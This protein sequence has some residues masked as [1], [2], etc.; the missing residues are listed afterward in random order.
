MPSFLPTSRPTSRLGP[1]AASTEPPRV[2][3]PHTSPSTRL[4]K[5]YNE[6]HNHGSC[7]PPGICVCRPPWQGYD[8]SERHDGEPPDDFSAD[9]G[10]VYVHSPPNELGL[11]AMR[12]TGLHLDALYSA[13]IHFF[14]RLMSDFS[15]RTRDPR[16]ARLFYVPTFLIPIFTNIVYDKGVSHQRN[17]VAALEARDPL[18]ASAWHHN[19]S[20]VVFF[21]AGDKG[22]CLWQRGPIYLTH[23]GLT[24]PWKAMMLPHLWRSDALVSARASEA[25]CADDHDI[26]VPPVIEK[27]P[28]AD[29]AITRAGSNRTFHMPPERPPD[30]A[31]E[32]ELFFAGA[33]TAEQKAAKSSWCDDGARGGV[34]CYSQGVRAAVFAHHANRS[35]FCLRSRLPS[36]LFEHSRFCLAPSGEGF[37]DRLPTSALAGCVPLII[38]PAVKQPYDD[39][40][41]YDRFAVRI[42]ADKIPILHELLASVTPEQ[43]ARLRAGVRQY[44]RAF[45]WLRSGGLAY[46]VARYSLCLRATSMRPEGCMHLCPDM[47]HLLGHH[48]SQHPHHQRAWANASHPA[49]SRTPAAG[50][51]GDFNVGRVDGSLVRVPG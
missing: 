28:G 38:Q 29:K 20:R 13:E 32:C 51:F 22:A 8:C 50:R 34:R 43:H 48:S 19:R 49:G 5:C 2:Q 18:F 31:Y 24:T 46:E 4:S 39:V 37:G 16:R 47:Q 33:A 44:A 11:T 35:G 41:P 10:F 15:L 7:A 6:C 40:L 36:R 26:V 30:L 21:M 17:L 14:E 42:G 1:S 9:T 3:P 45:D 25:P 23:F 27:L 12:R